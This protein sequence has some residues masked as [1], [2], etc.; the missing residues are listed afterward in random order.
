MV[1]EKQSLVKLIFFMKPGA[2]DWEGPFIPI[3]QTAGDATSMRCCTEN[4]ITGSALVLYPDLGDQKCKL[5]L[6]KSHIHMETMERAPSIRVLMNQLQ[7]YTDM[8]ATEDDIQGRVNNKKPITDYSPLC[9]SAIDNKGYCGRLTQVSRWDTAKSSIPI[10]FSD[11]ETMDDVDIK[12]LFEN[13]RVIYLDTEQL[14]IA[15]AS[16]LRR[17]SNILQVPC[18]VLCDR[19]QVEQQLQALTKEKENKDEQEGAVAQQETQA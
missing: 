19:K 9:L 16:Q 1:P 6:V 12:K 11:L 4:A 14:S 5:I 8:D 13:E 7:S 18:Y 15:E 17:L 10:S 2:G 3:W